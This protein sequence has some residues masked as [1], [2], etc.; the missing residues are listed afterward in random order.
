M[1]GGETGADTYLEKE[2]VF[3]RLNRGLSLIFR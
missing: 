3:F 2:A 1:F